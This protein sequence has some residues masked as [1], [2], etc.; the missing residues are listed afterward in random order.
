[1]L[2]LPGIC[3]L[4]AAGLAAASA[5]Q[6]LAPEPDDKLAP[7]IDALESDEWA[8]RQH[9]EDALRLALDD[10]GALEDALETIDRDLSPEAR[11]RL[12]ILGESA[13]FRSERPGVGISFEAAPDGIRI[14]STVDGFDAA[15]KLR[16]GD[17]ILSFGGLAIGNED[18]MRTAIMVHDPGDEVEITLRRNNELVKL[19]LRLGWFRDLNPDRARQPDRS[20]M[21]RAW[22]ERAG[23]KLAGPDT[24][25][26]LG[27]DE[28]LWRRAD[29]VANQ[30]RSE[31]YRQRGR[32]ERLLTPGV[33]GPG[34]ALRPQGFI[35]G[36]RSNNRV[37]LHPQEVLRQIDDR[38]GAIT[39][40]I[41]ELE[42]SAAAPDL[43]PR[44][45]G[46]IELEIQ[47]LREARVELLA[48]RNFDAIT[49]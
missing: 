47:R 46:R 22:T 44:E 2:P 8:V 42:A 29:D 43:D 25:V 30:A 35:G 36:A 15:D 13:F 4:A 3:L 26:D 20:A 24:V 21:R 40:R 7:L 12:N 49:P 48:L 31:L 34:S 28:S 5:A 39:L 33:A 14:I 17:V 19:D 23:R 45:V 37:G 11:R 9:A 38:I 10:L 16:A 27:L 6:P 18:A 1:M 41:A 32:S